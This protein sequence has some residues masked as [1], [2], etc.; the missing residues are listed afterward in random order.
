MV[1]RYRRL[2]D[3]SPDDYGAEWPE[4]MLPIGLSDPG[5]ACYDV[6]SGRIVYWDEEESF[7]EL[8][9]PTYQHSFAPEADT[10]QAWLEDWLSRPPLAEQMKQQMEAALLE[11][12]RTTLAY[13][14]AKSTEE[15]AEFGLSGEGWEEQ[16][17]GHLGIDLGEL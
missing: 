17:F 1:D 12:M 14:R 10:L 13:W 2:V 8:G 9:E 5:P 4:H 11:N 15:R 16:L 6:R 3:T 7:D